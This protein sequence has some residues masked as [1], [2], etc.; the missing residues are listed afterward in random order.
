M[1][2]LIEQPRRAATFPIARASA[3]L[4]ADISAVSPLELFPD[5]RQLPH[6]YI[7]HAV[8]HDRNAPLIRRGEIVVVDIGGSAVTGG[9]VPTEGGL[10]LIEHSSPPVHGERYARR[11]RDI[12]QTFTDDLG[13]WCAGSSRRGNQGCE[14]LCAD[15]P[16]PDEFAL[17]D[18]LIGKIVGLY[19]PTGALQ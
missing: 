14:F 16:Y 4:S 3:I 2:R 13:R 15:G 18:K 8:T 5:M 9:W 7:V 19:S 1:G 10:F 12:V 17:A 6:S 11:S